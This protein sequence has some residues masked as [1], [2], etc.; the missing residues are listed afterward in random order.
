MEMNKYKLL[1]RIALDDLDV[2]RTNDANIK[3]VLSDI[4]Q[5]ESD[6]TILAQIAELAASLNCPHQAST[7][8]F[9]SLV[10]G[11]QPSNCLSLLFQNL[12]DLIKE[13]QASVAKQ[14]QEKQS[15]DSR[16]LCLELT[17]TTQ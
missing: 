16:L 3:K 13:M 9:F 7:N 11:F 15:S 6:A 5:L 14:L 1:M 2:A 4:Q 12:D 17:V 8:K 10:V